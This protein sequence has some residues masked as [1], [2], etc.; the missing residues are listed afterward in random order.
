[1]RAYSENSLWLPL[2]FPVGVMNL[3]QD[4]P[5]LIMPCILKNHTYKHTNIY[6][7]KFKEHPVKP[8]RVFQCVVEIIKLSELYIRVT[9]LI[10]GF[11]LSA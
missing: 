3:S 10:M 6:L 1:M 8:L 9:L 2:G 7:N 5:R 4:H 11:G